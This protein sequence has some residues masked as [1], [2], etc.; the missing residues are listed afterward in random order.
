MSDKPTLDE[1]L[2]AIATFGKIA[3]L[4]DEYIKEAHRLDPAG[5]PS[6][7]GF[8][9]IESSH[10]GSIAIRYEEYCSGD[11]TTET[12]Y[13]PIADLLAFDFEAIRAARLE[14]EAERARKIE[15]ERALAKAHEERRERDQLRK[16]RAKYPDEA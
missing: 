4:V 15:R 13:I 3:L 2:V 5:W 10:E 6:S 9:D 12:R 1:Y 14:R 8:I 11:T 16:L 7:Y